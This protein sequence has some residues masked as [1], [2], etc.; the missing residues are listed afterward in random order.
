MWAYLP[1]GGE[2]V[3]G[4]KQDVARNLEVGDLDGA[5]EANEHV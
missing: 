1:N 3:A 5:E 4:D 2:R